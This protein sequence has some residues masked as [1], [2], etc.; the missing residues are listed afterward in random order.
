MSAVH[1]VKRDEGGLTGWCG[2]EALSGICLKV[3]LCQKGYRARI[4]GP[5]T[6]SAHG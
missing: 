4:G 3:G 5:R 6:V 1:G 2:N